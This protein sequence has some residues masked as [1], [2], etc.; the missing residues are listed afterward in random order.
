MLGLQLSP[1]LDLLGVV[2][3]MG[4]HDVLHEAREVGAPI[5]QSTDNKVGTLLCVSTQIDRP[6]IC[7][8][9]GDEEGLLVSL[10]RPSS[11]VSFW[12]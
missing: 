9:G 8:L 12:C 3:Q 7:Q 4:A 11:L 1:F 2:L 5:T 6:A 10:Q